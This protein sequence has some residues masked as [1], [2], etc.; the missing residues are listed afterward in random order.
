MVKIDLQIPEEWFVDEFRGEDFVSRRQ[1]EIWAVELDMLYK[2]QQICEKHNIKW[3]I[4]AGTLLGAVR[5]GGFIPWD[6]DIDVV[7]FPD[8]YDKF[9]QVAAQELEEPYFLQTDDRDNVFYCHTKIRRTDTTG[10][11]T[12]DRA[13]AF[14]FN[15]GIFIDIFPL[16]FV[17]SDEQLY[18][19]YVDYLALTKKEML[20]AKN[21]Y[22]NYAR[23][24]ESIINHA[25]ELRAE[26][27]IIRRWYKDSGS[28]VVANLSLP[29]IKP[30]IRK[31]TDEFQDTIYM[32]FEMLNVPAPSGFNT[33]LCRLYGDYMKPV[34]AQNMH[35]TVIFNADKSY[36][37]SPFIKG[38]ENWINPFKNENDS[39]N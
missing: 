5:H 13:A 31:Y 11:L 30:E 17:P 6:D 9:N 12:K 29:S 36:K 4:D 18:I 8:D 28:N 33:I 39:N 7:M 1:K 34:K 35:G 26:Y 24:N 23:D 15:Q 16:D 21:R 19:D 10:I 38:H 14:D 25:K 37:E 20:F 27:E 3:W 22:W 2:V 32:D